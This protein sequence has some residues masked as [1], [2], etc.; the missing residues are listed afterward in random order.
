VR[1]NRSTLTC[2]QPCVYR[3]L[4]PVWWVGWVSFWK[5]F[6]SSNSHHAALLACCQ[7]VLKPSS[8][9]N[10]SI[11][12][13]HFDLSQRTPSPKAANSQ[14]VRSDSHFPQCQCQQIKHSWFLFFVAKRC[15]AH[16]CIILWWL[17]V[18]KKSGAQGAH[19]PAPQNESFKY[20]KLVF[21]KDDI[22]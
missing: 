2:L 22:T 13:P 17:C 19:R 5:L 10:G 1:V 20:L 8:S 6:F 9:P 15:F 3:A 12:T 16:P 21:S 7:T 18:F 14:S 11:A 4:R